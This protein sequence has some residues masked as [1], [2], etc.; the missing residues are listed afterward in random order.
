[1][2]IP[3]QKYLHLAAILLAAAIM[4][5]MS[6]CKTSTCAA[7]SYAPMQPVHKQTWNGNQKPKTVKKKTQHYTYKKK[8]SKVQQVWANLMTVNGWN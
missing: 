5:T 6:S 3:L 1:M 2:R 8:Q 4:L 7:Y